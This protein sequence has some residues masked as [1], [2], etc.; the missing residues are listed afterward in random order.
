[1]LPFV[2]ERACVKVNGFKGDSSHCRTV[3]TNKFAPGKV[4][5]E[6]EGVGRGMGI[7]GRGHHSGVKTVKVLLCFP[8]HTDTRPTVPGISHVRG[9]VRKHEEKTVN[10]V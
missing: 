1:M 5:S 8:S 2:K 7:G 9:H 4:T 6:S 10:A 3:E